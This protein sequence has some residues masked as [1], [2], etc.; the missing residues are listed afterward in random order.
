MGTSAVALTKIFDRLLADPWA[1]ATDAE[2]PAPLKL[3]ALAGAFRGFGGEFMRPPKAW[4]AAQTLY[5]SDGEN[6]WQLVSDRY[7]CLLTR[8]DNAPKP[9]PAPADTHILANGMVTWGKDR[10]NEPSLSSASSWACN[11]QTLAATSANSH[12]VFLFAK[13]TANPR[14]GSDAV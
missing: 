3:A 1:A 2:T 10:V 13:T 12:H 4:S 7:G 11:G 5:V 14:G 9:D 6:T 8:V